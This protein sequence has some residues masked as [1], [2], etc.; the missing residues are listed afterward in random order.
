MSSGGH[1][2]EFILSY[3][4]DSHRKPSKFGGT[5]HIILGLVAKYVVYLGISSIKLELDIWET[6]YKL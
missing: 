3:F 5:Q 1:S 4:D 6:W 2:T